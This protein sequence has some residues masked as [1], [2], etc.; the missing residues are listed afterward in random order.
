MRLPDEKLRG[1]LA[2]TVA[3]AVGSCGVL[4]TGPQ[5]DLARPDAT[6]IAQSAV[7][8]PAADFPVVLG[9][10]YKIDGFEYTPADTWNYDEV[11]YA[12]SE[13]GESVTAS[14]KTLPLPSYIEVTSL[15]NGKTILVRVERRGPLTNARLVGLSAQAQ[16]IL[17]AEEGTAVRVR[18]VNPPESQRAPLRQGQAA[19]GRLDT[20]MSLVAVLKR[21]LPKAGAASLT[22]KAESPANAPAGEIP[23]AKSPRIT[24]E[25]VL[26]TDNPVVAEPPEINTV[27]MVDTDQLPKSDPAPKDNIAAGAFV[28]QAAAFSSK[29][30]AKK[31]AR[32]LNG[33]VDPK[34]KFFRVRIGPY[35]SR[36][37]ADAALAKARAAG[38]KDARVIK[39]G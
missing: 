38:Y 30:N 1:A 37:Q 12:T 19:P 4:A 23:K 20:P 16:A 6:A 27:A 8:G 26:G 24:V 13:P 10:P 3:L 2:L 15:E 32:I 34:G 22:D 17:E 33:F 31:A 35:T 7:S 36:G 14:H 21:K 39:A 5:A 29:E 28:V 18:R 9:D 25:K 11:G